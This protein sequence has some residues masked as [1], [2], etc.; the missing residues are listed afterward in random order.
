MDECRDFAVG[1]GP[2]LDQQIAITEQSMSLDFAQFA[3]HVL[4]EDAGTRSKQFDHVHWIAL[5][6]WRGASQWRT[7]SLP[8]CRS[9]KSSSTTAAMFSA[10]RT[11]A[12][13]KLLAVSGLRWSS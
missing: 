4:A 9:A 13:G 10:Q 2:G 1:H 3:E 5:P 8:R 12:S 6:I 7:I 11:L